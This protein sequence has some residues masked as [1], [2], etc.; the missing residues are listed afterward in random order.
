MGGGGWGVDGGGV[1]DV[2]DGSH[3]FLGRFVCRVLVSVVE[4]LGGAV[5]GGCVVG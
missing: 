5:P 3:F 2:V 4:I 1:G